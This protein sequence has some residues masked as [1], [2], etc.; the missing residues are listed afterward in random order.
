MYFRLPKVPT[1]L[2]QVDRNRYKEHKDSFGGRHKWSLDANIHRHRFFR[3]DFVL[4]NKISPRSFET[5]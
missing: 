4:F 5:N 2:V 1:K 3:N